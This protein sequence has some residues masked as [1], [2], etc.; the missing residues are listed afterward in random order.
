MV[1][2]DSRSFKIFVEKM[3]LSE[4]L[5]DLLRFVLRIIVSLLATV[6]RNLISRSVFFDSQSFILAVTRKLIVRQSRSHYRPQSE[7]ICS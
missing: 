1:L 5:S 3:V 2:S 7:E 6:T 4:T